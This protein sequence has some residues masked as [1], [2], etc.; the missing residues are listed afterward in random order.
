VNP[1][2]RDGAPH[3]T[4]FFAHDRI[5]EEHAASPRSDFVCRDG[6]QGRTRHG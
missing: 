1:F 5:G 2:E 6:A 3:M 4:V